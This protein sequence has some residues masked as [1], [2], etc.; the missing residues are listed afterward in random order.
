[1]YFASLTGIKRTLAWAVV[2]VAP[3]ALYVKST[4]SLSAALACVVVVAVGIYGLVTE[5]LVITGALSFYKG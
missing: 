5:F 4:R 2:I 3:I 1:M